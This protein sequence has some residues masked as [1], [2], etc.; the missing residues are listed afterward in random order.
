MCLLIDIGN[1]RLKWA[2]HHNT[3]IT[4]GKPIPAEPGKLDDVFTKC[5][6]TIKP[7]ARVLVSNV[8]GYQLA[9]TLTEWVQQNWYITTEFVQ[10]EASAH[11]VFNAYTDPQKLGV[12][13][14]LGLLAV[15]SFTH[16]AACIVDCGTAITIDILDASGHH[17]GGLI[18]PGLTTMTAAL[19]HGTHA[20]NEVSMTTGKI[21]GCNTNDA[22]QSGILFAARGMIQSALQASVTELKQ[23]VSLF[24]TG[25]DAEKIAA[26]ISHPHQIFPN[27]VLTGLAIVESGSN[28]VEI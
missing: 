17:L 5:W 8:A 1:S 14:W 19:F 7:P 3:V 6:S 4:P 22:I 11:G 28:C 25:G 24:F 20:I 10:S 16:E 2:I 13:R 15:R 12:D 9:E 27:L 18:A 26:E 21:F 23:N